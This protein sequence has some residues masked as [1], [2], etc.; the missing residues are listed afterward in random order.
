[1]LYMIQ[2]SPKRFVN[3]RFKRCPQLGRNGSGAFQY[4]V[5]YGE[6]RSHAVIIASFQMMSRHQVFHRSTPPFTFAEEVADVQE[7][8]M[9]VPPICK[10]TI[11]D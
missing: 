10:R 5:I 2:T 3:N 6:C 7:F 8:P 1:L 9:K 11:F 4:I